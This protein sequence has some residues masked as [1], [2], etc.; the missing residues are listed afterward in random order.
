MIGVVERVEDL[1]LDG[2]EMGEVRIEVF[3][4]L[5]IERRLRQWLQV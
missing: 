4:A 1:C 5:V 2:V 3:Q